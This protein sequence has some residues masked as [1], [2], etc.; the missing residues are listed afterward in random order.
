MT[1]EDTFVNLL[2]W[3]SEVK[4]HAAEDVRIYLVGNKSELTDQREVTYERAVEMAR[5]NKIHRV[6]ETSAKTGSNVEE[7]FASV[8]K[9]LYC[10]AKQEAERLAADKVVPE[11]PVAVTV[12]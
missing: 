10:Q 8:A 5:A 3:L 2:Q 1:R 9:E 11:K 12:N 7:V 4:Q 6:F